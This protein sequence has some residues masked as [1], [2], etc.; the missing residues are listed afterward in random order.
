MYIYIYMYMYIYMYTARNASWNPA[1][2]E[3]STGNQ[4]ISSPAVFLVIRIGKV[5]LYQF[6]GT[7]QTNRYV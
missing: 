2:V 1:G 3:P 5:R 6:Y 7:K 4:R